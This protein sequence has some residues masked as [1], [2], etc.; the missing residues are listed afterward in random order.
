MQIIVFV[1]GIMGS[2]LAAPDGTEVWPPTPIEGG[3]AGYHRIDQLVRPDLTP[4]GVIHTVC[5]DF[6]G[7]LLDHLAAGTAA[8]GDLLIEHAYDWRRDLATL[9]DELSVRLD[10]ALAQHPGASIV[11][12]A[13][14]MGGLIVRAC[15]ERPHAIP[16]RWQAAVTLATFLAVP[17]EGAPLAFARA[18]GVGGSSA[19]LGAAE[20]RKLAGMP[21]FP[22]AYQL[23]S[24]PPLT[25]LWRLDGPIPFAGVTLFD[26]ANIGAFGLNARHLAAATA[27]QTLLDP[28]RKPPHCRY[29]AVASATHKT[30]TRFDLQGG[31]AT[32]VWVG[33][34]GDG[35]VPVRSATALAIQTAYVDAD[36]VG[37]TQDRHTLDLIDMLLGYATP[38]AVAAGLEAQSRRIVL[39]VSPR[40]ASSTEPYEIV[41]VTGGAPLAGD[42]LIE[43]QSGA[44]FTLAE[45]V[46]VGVT[47]PGAARLVLD[48]V[49]LPPGAYRFRLMIAG[50][51]VATAEMAVM[52]QNAG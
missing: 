52:V 21:G 26:P 41:V 22:A 31:G 14:S 10:Q 23:F 48:R 40:L 44:G 17:Q 20:Q 7:T 49:P 4:T 35:T 8:H 15:L 13:H 39:S 42:I 19:G 18:I 25:P 38:A 36:H 37:V 46:P 28:A 29:F 32:P 51:A 5:V 1:P 11:L 6:Y 3:I 9:A 16:L 30:L 47:A 50:Q 45:T 12:I 27:F 2:S 33:G 24:P 43:R 34:T